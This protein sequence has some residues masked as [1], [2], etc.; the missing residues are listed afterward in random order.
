MSSPSKARGY[1]QLPEKTEESFNGECRFADGT[2]RN[3]FLRTGDLGFLYRGELFVCGR[4]KDLIILRGRNHYPQDIER[5]CEA[6][7]GTDIR[8]GCSAAFSIPIGGEEVLVY[9]CEVN[10]EARRQTKDMNDKLQGIIANMLRECSKGHGVNLSVVMLIQPRTIIKTTS[11]K[12]SRAKTRAA[13][14]N[15]QLKVVASWNSFDNDA[16]DDDDD[17]YIVSE[18]HSVELEEGQTLLD[19]TE[20]D[21]HE[22]IE[23]LKT[24]SAKTLN[25][26]LDDVKFD[27][28]LANL[29]MD[30]IRGALLL[31]KL[32]K[33]F[34][35]Q[36]PMD[37][38]FEP[39]TSLKTIAMSLTAGSVTQ[40]CEYIFQ[41]DLIY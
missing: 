1:W 15:S 11:G 28:P 34:S 25:M 24:L 7:G 31:S 35:V 23:I 37:L 3:G 36:I 8:P 20:M 4:L 13:Y 30:S 10:E 9:V 19:P 6:A 18:Q 39:D 12:I 32:E 33:T 21:Q 27:V 2:T 29:A 26:P 16:G 41:T 22:V 38:V 17:D 5:T 40:L 14:L